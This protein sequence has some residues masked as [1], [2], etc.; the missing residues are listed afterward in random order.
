[1]YLK[2]LREFCDD[3]SEKVAYTCGIAR[4]PAPRISANLSRNTRSANRYVAAVGFPNCVYGYGAPVNA[5]HH[6]NIPS[7]TPNQDQD[8]DAAR[9]VY[10]AWN[11]SRNAPW[12]RRGRG[13]SARQMRSGLQNT[14]STGAPPDFTYG[15]PTTPRACSTS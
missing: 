7:Y 12:P 1:M 13:K 11:A 2:A 10:T 14:S 9:T 15:P 4:T 8:S 6:I 3:A 5:Y